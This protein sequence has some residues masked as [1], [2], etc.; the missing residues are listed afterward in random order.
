MYK[1]R[2]YTLPSGK[3]PIKEFLLNSQESLRVKITKQ[4]KH[5]GEFGLTF[6]NPNLKK[7][8]G[9]PLWEVRI[10]GRDSARIICVAIVKERIVIIHIFRKKS[11][12]TSSKDIKIAMSRFKTLTSDIQKGII[13]L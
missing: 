9:T 3:S 10:L 7:L 1:V 4:I 12:K 11:N 13:E 5:L 8:T 2:F 6:S